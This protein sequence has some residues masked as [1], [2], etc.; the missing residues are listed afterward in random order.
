MTRDNVP[1][2]EEWSVSQGEHQGRP[3]FVRIKVSAALYAGQRELPMRL[4]IAVPLIAGDERG[5]PR[6]EEASQLDSIEEAL[7][8]AVESSG[9]GRIVLVITTNGMREFVAYTRSKEAAEAA[10]SHAR[11]AVKT[12]RI[13][14][15]TAPDPKGELL[16]EFSSSVG[17]E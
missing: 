14:H 16:R 11:A 13:Q 6:I 17:P 3:M 1:P 8:G 9:I 5:L 10:V 15:Y 4:G 2:G 7:F 12:H